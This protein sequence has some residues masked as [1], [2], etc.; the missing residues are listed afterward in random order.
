MDKGVLLDLVSVC[1]QSFDLV[2]T[3]TNDPGA[4]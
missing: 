1:T 3:W 4:L 2:E